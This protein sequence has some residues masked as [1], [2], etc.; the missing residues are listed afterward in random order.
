MIDF[1]VINSP[2]NVEEIFERGIRELEEI[3]K[4]SQIE[5]K[6]DLRSIPLISTEFDMIDLSNPSQSELNELES[7]LNN[8]ISVINPTN[9]VSKYSITEEFIQKYSC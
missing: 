6:D 7:F 5:N 3:I 2:F 1:E 8:N 9:F 4:D